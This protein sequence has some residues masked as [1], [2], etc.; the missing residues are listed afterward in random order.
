MISCVACGQ[1]YDDDLTKAY[2][3]H[4]GTNVQVWSCCQ[5]GFE[6]AV[7]INNAQSVGRVVYLPIGDSDD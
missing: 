2:C 1:E 5:C 7:V 3:G 6:F 4:L